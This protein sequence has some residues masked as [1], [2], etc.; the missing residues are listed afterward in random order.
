MSINE[1]KV[2]D[3]CLNIINKIN[4]N[5]FKLLDVK[6][7]HKN[8]NECNHELENNYQFINNVNECKKVNEL[9]NKNIS[10][11]NNNKIF[12]I[13][14][15]EHINCVQKYENMKK[16]NKTFVCVWPQCKYSAK[17]KYHLNSHVLVH[18]QEKT[19]KCDFNNCNKSFK[20]K[21]SL[22]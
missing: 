7:I 6:K 11:Y 20:Q 8:I 10:E 12:K 14:I 17:Y 1:K 18:S 19:F 2:N 15:K 22:K 13:Y 9:N 16:T 4:K 5:V 3:L 21:S